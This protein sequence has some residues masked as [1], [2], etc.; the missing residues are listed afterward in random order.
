MRQT[1]RMNKADRLALMERRIRSY[2]EAK[3]TSA[4]ALSMAATGQPNIVRTIY[5]GSEPLGGRVA[6]LARTMG[7]TA[8]RLTDPDPAVLMP[9]EITYPTGEGDAPGL[10]GD[11]YTAPPGASVHGP[12]LDLGDPALFREMFAA[13]QRVYREEEIAI[14]DADLAEMVFT[15]FHTIA[16]EFDTEDQ[17]RRHARVTVSRTRAALRR[18]RAQGL[19]ARPAHREKTGS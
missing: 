13:M 3:K 1:V 17:R 19:L 10:S 5:A 12:G 7:V 16:A 8:D 15:D 9:W 2:I 14:E 11:V 6:A 18:S 4:R